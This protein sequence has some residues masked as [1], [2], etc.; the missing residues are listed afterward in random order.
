MVSGHST[1]RTFV[2]SLKQ[3]KER[4][5]RTYF[6]Y[7]VS[8]QSFCWIGKST[9]Y[10]QLFPPLGKTSNPTR[11]LK[12]DDTRALCVNCATRSV[13]AIYQDPDSILTEVWS[14]PGF[15]TSRC[16]T[17]YGFSL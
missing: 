15:R 8:E 1:Y 13:D 12:R 2:R 5:T 17:E 16:N 3:V 9:D 14:Y 4:E 11:M 7:E 6:V 10:I